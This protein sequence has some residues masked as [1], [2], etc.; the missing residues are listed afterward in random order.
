[1]VRHGGKDPVVGGT[2]EED[3]T[4]AHIRTTAIRTAVFEDLAG[5]RKQAARLH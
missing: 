5:R 1:V 3:P 2:D 4:A